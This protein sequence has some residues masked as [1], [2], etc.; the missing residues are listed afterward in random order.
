VQQR[1]LTLT[2]TLALTLTLSLSLTLALPHTHHLILFHGGGLFQRE[3]R[4]LH[5]LLVRW[6]LPAIHIILRIG[7]RVSGFGCM[8]EG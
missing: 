4:D 8:V 5:L 7:Y 6:G 1:S 3:R 2:L